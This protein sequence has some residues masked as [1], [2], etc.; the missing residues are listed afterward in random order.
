VPRGWENGRRGDIKGCNEKSYTPHQVLSSV[1]PHTHIGGE[2][3]IA[4]CELGFR[5][6]TDDPTRL[7]GQE[8]NQ[9]PSTLIVNI[10]VCIY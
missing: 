10:F 9:N 6:V 7:Q 2:Y 4:I 5:I 3:I 8:T 1:V